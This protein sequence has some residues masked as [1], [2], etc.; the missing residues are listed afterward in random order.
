M[1]YLR[2]ARKREWQENYQHLVGD[3]RRRVYGKV[4]ELLDREAARSEIKALIVDEL[5][6]DGIT[7]E[8]EWYVEGFARGLFEDGSAYYR[9]DL[10]LL[11]QRRA[12][13]HNHLGY[14]AGLFVARQRVA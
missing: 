1:E 14:S 12:N 3:L 4:D 7:D 8:L 13:K 11:Q 10:E 5:S 6:I 2:E 9:Q